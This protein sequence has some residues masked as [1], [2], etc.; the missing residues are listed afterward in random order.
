M[1]LTKEN[2]EAKIK[3]HGAQLDELQ[4]KR[5]Q[6]NDAITN[7]MNN[8]MELVG[9]IKQLQILKAELYPKDPV[10]ET[11]KVLADLDEIVDQ[12]PEEPT[13]PDETENEVTEPAE[14]PDPPE[15]EGQEVG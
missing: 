15:V 8:G 3:K 5:K 12:L 6:F 11:E 4:T 1:E 14:I 2:I 13:S 7:N 9:A 10:E